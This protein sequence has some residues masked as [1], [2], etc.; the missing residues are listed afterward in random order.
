MQEL[1]ILADVD[2]K[3]GSSEDIGRTHVHLLRFLGMS[4]Q[5]NSYGNLHGDQVRNR[6][7]LKKIRSEFVITVSVVAYL[8]TEAKAAEAK[9]VTDEQ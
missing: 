9:L 4:L 3:N 2:V 6:V 5:G 1:G 8:L 7:T